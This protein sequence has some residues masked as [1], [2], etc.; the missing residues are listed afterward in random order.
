[1]RSYCQKLK[2][3]MIRKWNSLIELSVN[4]L[5]SWYIKEGSPFDYM[6]RPK[7]IKDK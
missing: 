5:R 6:P 7:F 1:M 2:Y 3:R 4:I